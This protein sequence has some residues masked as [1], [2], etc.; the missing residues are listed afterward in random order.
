MKH[1]EA[2]SRTRSK[3][4][5]WLPGV[6]LMSSNVSSSTSFSLKIRIALIGSP[7][8]FGSWN[9]VVLTKPVVLDEEHGNDTVPQHGSSTQRDRRDMPK[10]WLFSGWNW[11]PRVFPR[12]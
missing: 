4:G 7:T 11:T 3:L 1:S 8:Y 6:A 2:T 12:R 10:R 9:F 5:P